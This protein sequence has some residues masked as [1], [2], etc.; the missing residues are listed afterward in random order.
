MVNLI[1]SINCD[2]LGET[3][4]LSQS[5]TTLPISHLK[6]STV[7]IN[8]IATIYLV[9]GTFYLIAVSTYYLVV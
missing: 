9:G 7:Y 8:F 2:P 3:D 1:W 4:C 5:A 6:E